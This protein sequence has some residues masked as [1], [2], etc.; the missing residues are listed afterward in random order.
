MGMN[1]LCKG[2][3][4]MDISH[5]RIFEDPL[6]GRSGSK[7][8]LSDFKIQIDGLK[9]SIESISRGR[10]T[11]SLS[12]GI[13]KQLIDKAKELN[14]F[15][16][17]IKRPSE[18]EK[19]EARQ[20]VDD[21]F[22]CCEKKIISESYGKS[23]QVIMGKLTR[24]YEEIMLSPDTGLIKTKLK[25]TYPNIE[26]STFG[27][28][29][30]KSHD[31]TKLSSSIMQGIENTIT[32]RTEEADNKLQKQ[33]EAAQSFITDSIG[34]DSET[35]SLTSSDSNENLIGIYLDL[36]LQDKHESYSK[37]KSEFDTLKQE[38]NQL[39]L[40][41]SEE[42]DHLDED[43]EQQTLIL[44][45]HMAE[46]NSLNERFNGLQQRIEDALKLN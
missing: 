43:T 24:F 32:T 35:D 45:R 3:I 11:G 38:Q 12:K 14:T 17:S 19:I 7:D 26:A 13:N 40:R 20:L 31:A 27:A 30:F 46:G 44:D 29:I 4:R 28:T 5:N 36:L 25:Y 41:Q 42:L 18:V 2:E 10:F 37:F 22:S 16:V 39:E 15:V 21:F 9:K 34:S 6:T 8:K 23:N 33:I 1:S